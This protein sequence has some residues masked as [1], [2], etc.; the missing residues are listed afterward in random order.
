VFHAYY[1]ELVWA[2]YERRRDAQRVLCE[3]RRRDRGVA[4]RPIAARPSRRAANHTALETAAF[5]IF[6]YGRMIGAAAEI[7]DHLNHG[8]DIDTAGQSINA[9]RHLI[10]DRSAREQQHRSPLLTAR[11]R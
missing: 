7:D 11:Q 4:A 5:N 2:R 9:I 3:H 10:H 8:R 6:L 1:R